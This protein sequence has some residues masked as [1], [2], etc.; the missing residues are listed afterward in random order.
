MC[1]GSPDAP[2]A[3]VAYGHV[4]VNTMTAYLHVKDR[5]RAAVIAVIGAAAVAGAMAA[6]AQATVPGKNGAIAFSHRGS[7]FVVK[8]G[9][10]RAAQAAPPGQGL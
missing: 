2:E 1:G 5:A 4:M 10:H 6:L 3:G 8:P 9:R 7:L